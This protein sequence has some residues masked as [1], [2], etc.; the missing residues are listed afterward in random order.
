MGRFVRPRLRSRSFAH[1]FR[2]IETCAL[3]AVGGFGKFRC[4]DRRVTHSQSAT[5]RRANLSLLGIHLPLR[6]SG[7]RVMNKPKFLSYRARWPHASRTLRSHP[8]LGGMRPKERKGR[9]M[10]QYCQSKTSFTGRCN[11][12]GVKVAVRP[13]CRP[14]AANDDPLPRHRLMNSDRAAVTEDDW[15]TPSAVT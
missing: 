8:H 2:V 4:G 5:R 15:T 13:R 11:C 12:L 9:S 14:S 6:L 1:T 3:Y 10:T 7:G